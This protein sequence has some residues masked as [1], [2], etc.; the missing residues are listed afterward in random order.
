MWWMGWIMM[1]QMVW[2]AMRA[3]RQLTREAV[4]VFH[5][6]DREVM[7]EEMLD[8]SSIHPAMQPKQQ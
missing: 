8:I 3:K 4:E 1:K 7:T 2:T 5:A 6:L